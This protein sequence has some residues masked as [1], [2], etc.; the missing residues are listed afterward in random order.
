MGTAPQTHERPQLPDQFRGELPRVNEDKRGFDRHRRT[1]ILTQ[2]LFFE[3][4]SQRYATH[5]PN[6]H[7]H[8][9]PRRGPVCVGGVAAYHLP[10]QSGRLGVKPRRR[11]ARIA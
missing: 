4:D 8:V 1:G 7:G 9:S 10:S 3:D 6:D 11:R 5:H 2:L